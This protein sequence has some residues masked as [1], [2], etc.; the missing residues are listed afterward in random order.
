MKHHSLS[1]F[2][3][4]DMTIDI[5]QL[6]CLECVKG[7]GGSAPQEPERTVSGDAMRNKHRWFLVITAGE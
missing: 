4:H 5:H 1:F 7:E 3:T 6:R 2:M